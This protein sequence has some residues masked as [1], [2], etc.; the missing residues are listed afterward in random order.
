MN[1]VLNEIT[2]EMLVAMSIL[3]LLPTAMTATAKASH[4]H[5]SQ[6]FAK[7]LLFECSCCYCLPHNYAA[8]TSHPC[9]SAE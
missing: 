7:L 8:A 1:V 5:C 4:V 6:M 9:C 2:A 3:T